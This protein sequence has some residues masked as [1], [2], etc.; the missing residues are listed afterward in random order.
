MHTPFSPPP[1]LR[2]IREWVIVDDT[3]YAAAKKCGSTS[4]RQYAIRIHHKDVPEGMY[5]VGIV[6][7]PIERFYSL[8]RHVNRGGGFGT[9][10][11]PYY[12]QMRGLTLAQFWRATSGSFEDEDHTR[13]QYHTIGPA[14]EFIRLENIE[15]E[16]KNQTTGHVEREDWIDKRLRFWYRRDFEIWE[17]ADGNTCPIDSSRT[18]SG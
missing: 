6:R 14:D 17:S 9:Y 12:E 16:R 2:P 10:V 4:L 7:N 15:W 13:H 1:P 11:G 8:Y 3:A 5:K 18:N